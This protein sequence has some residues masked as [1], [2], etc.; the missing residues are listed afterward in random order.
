MS[1]NVSATE[2]GTV[3]AR[4]PAGTYMDA[5]VT[6]SGEGAGLEF[7]VSHYAANDAPT[8]TEPRISVTMHPATMKA[9]T[10][11]LAERS[12]MPLFNANQWSIIEDSLKMR[13]VDREAE[14]INAP[15]LRE[16]LDILKAARS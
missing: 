3:S 8:G 2:S 13:L 4:I 9:L 5:F 12:G 15:H 1:F 10:A 16:M 11:L 14:N 7:A 6:R